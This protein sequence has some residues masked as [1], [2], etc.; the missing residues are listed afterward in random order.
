[1]A[2]TRVR[3]V[4]N[5]SP[6]SATSATFTTLPANIPAAD[7]VVIW[8]E[9][10]SGTSAVTASD[11]STQTGAANTYTVRFD[12]TNSNASV[13][14]VAIV[15]QVTRQ[16]QTTDTITVAF[17]SSTGS[18]RVVQYTGSSGFDAASTANNGTGASTTTNNVTS[19][20]SLGM[21][22]AGLATATSG[23]TVTVGTVGGG[24]ATVGSTSLEG[25]TSNGF[26]GRVS[27]EDAQFSTQGTI[28]G[29][30]TWASSVAFVAGII[31]L[32]SASIPA[33][34]SRS[35]ATT[36]TPHNTATYITNPQHLSRSAISTVQP[37]AFG[38]YT[39]SLIPNYIRGRVRSAIAS[40]P[41]S[42]IIAS[43]RSLLRGSPGGSVGG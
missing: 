11:N 25:Q 13:R 7:T 19:V 39:S 28:N 43:G 5:A 18:L 9:L 21:A 15:C 12:S 4:G 17:S 2:V 41:V 38:S 26:G 22:I 8:C 1:M 32:A 37:H 31:T 20:V 40:E 3:S 6:I 10:P 30:F 16:I 36:V 23:G 24:T 42:T 27:D 35:A 33:N 14:L 29:T 34:L